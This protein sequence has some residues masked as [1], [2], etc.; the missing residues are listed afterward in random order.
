ML[1]PVADMVA[2]WYME[3]LFAIIFARRARLAVIVRPSLVWMSCS[4]LYL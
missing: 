1:A 3:S 4:Y 2:C